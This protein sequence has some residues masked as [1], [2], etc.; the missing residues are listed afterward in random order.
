[1]VS[2]RLIRSGV[3]FLA[4]ILT[5]WVSS[6]PAMSSWLQSKDDAYAKTFGRKCVYADE[7]KDLALIYCQPE[8]DGPIYYVERATKKILATCGG[9]CMNGQCEGKCPPERW[10]SCKDKNK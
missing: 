10:I 4:V 7:C 8:V 5:V 1:M 2:R 9:E 6:A 3:C